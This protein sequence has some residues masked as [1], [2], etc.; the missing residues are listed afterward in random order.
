MTLLYEQDLRREEKM[1]SQTSRVKKKKEKK[2]NLKLQLKA[3]PLN[4][5]TAVIICCRALTGLLTTRNLASELEGPC[6]PSAALLLPCQT[7]STY[8][9]KVY[10]LPPP[11]SPSGSNFP[12]LG[13]KR[14][15]SPPVSFNKQFL[16]GAKCP[17]RSPEAQ[18]VPWV[19]ET[20]A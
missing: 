2:Q 15:S 20:A 4:V 11:T 19:P 1:V 8:C 3:Q 9:L 13:Y 14:G 6:F 7:G 10:D 17:L 16:Q 5:L 18:A 12:W